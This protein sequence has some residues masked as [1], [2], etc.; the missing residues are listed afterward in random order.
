MNLMMIGSL[1]DIATSFKPRSQDHTRTLNEYIR[2]REWKW[3]CECEWKLEHSPIS[4]G[5]LWQ[6][7]KVDKCN[8]NWMRNCDCSR[9]IVAIERSQTGNWR[10][11]TGSLHFTD[12]NKGWQRSQA[13]HKHVRQWKTN[14]NGQIN[15]QLSDF[16]TLP[17]L[18]FLSTFALVVLSTEAKN[19]KHFSNNQ[20]KKKKIKRKT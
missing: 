8:W 10:Q 2:H 9:Q 14:K 19:W 5:R 3:K 7:D 13:G 15:F 6:V 18:F 1:T 16:L 4:M 12:C 17:E 20:R 11:T